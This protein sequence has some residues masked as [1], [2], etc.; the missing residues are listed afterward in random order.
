MGS[1]IIPENPILNSDRRDS[2][3]SQRS[4]SQPPTQFPTQPVSQMY[5]PSIQ[6]TVPPL[7]LH[8]ESFENMKITYV[9][10]RSILKWSKLES[11]PSRHQIAFSPDLGSATESDLNT[12]RSEPEL[13][14]ASALSSVTEDEPKPTEP[15]Q[16][17]S[18]Y[19]QVNHVKSPSIG[20]NSDDM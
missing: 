8:K 9:N 6:N 20:R 19:N 4:G 11:E 3:A 10:D 15:W 2:R 16:N 12:D 5:Q 14:Q 18:E 13:R 17:N 7:Q 1:G